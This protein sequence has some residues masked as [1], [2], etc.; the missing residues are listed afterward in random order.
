MS[1]GKWASSVLMDLFPAIKAVH[2]QGTL[3]IISFVILLSKVIK[4]K[5]STK[6]ATIHRKQFYKMI[7]HTYDRLLFSISQNVYLILTNLYKLAL[8]SLW[9]ES[10]CKSC[11][12]PKDGIFSKATFRYGS[13]G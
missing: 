7:Y 5:V 12:A 3:V 13:G 9:E 6:I 1:A 2:K 10:I 8:N 11:S 4:T